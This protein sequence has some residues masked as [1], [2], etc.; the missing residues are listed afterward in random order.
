MSSPK[1]LPRGSAAAE[2]IVRRRMEGTS[3]DEDLCSREPIHIPGSIQPHGALLA[4][5]ADAL[6]IE[7][8]SA[9]AE[10]VL[11]VPVD[12]LLGRPLQDAVPDGFVL[13]LQAEM[14]AGLFSPV[15]PVHMLAPIRGG[16]EAADCWIHARDGLLVVEIERPG[17]PASSQ[18]RPRDLDRVVARLRDSATLDAMA[19]TLVRDLRRLTGFQRVLLYRFDPDWN[20]ET[21]AEDQVD[22][23]PQS[24]LGLRFPASDIPRQAR[25][26]YA[27]NPIRFL[28]ERDYTP[29]PLRSSTERNG[30]VLDLTG[31][32]LRSFS[33]IHLEYQR[34][35]G[36]DGAMS[37]SVLRDGKLWGLVVGHHRRPH[38]VPAEVA[39]AIGLVVTA[40]AMRLDEVEGEAEWS[41]HQRQS[42]TYARLLEQMAASDDLGAA[43]MDGAVTLPELFRAG[44]GALVRGGSMRLSGA[45]PPA[46]FIQGLLDWARAQTTERVFAH[47]SLPHA[48]AEA[49]PHAPSASG[50]LVVFLGPGREDAI[51]WFRS[52][53]TQE[54][55]WAGDPRKPTQGQPATG[56]LPRRSF[57]RWVENRTG[58]AQPWSRWEQETAE[59]LGHAIDEVILRH[60]RKL[61]ELSDKLQR[62]EQLSASQRMVEAS[63]NVALAEKDMLLAQKDVL[64]REVDHRV[65]NS[66]QLISSVM[67]L[68]AMSISDPAL[69]AEFSQASRRVTSVA[70]VHERLY[71]DREIRKVE[72]AAYLR[73]LCADLSHTAGGGAAIE[74]E[75]QPADVGTDQVIHLG[76]MVNEL[77]TNAFKYAAARSSAGRVR[78]T[79]APTPEGGYALDVEDDGPGVPEGFDPRKS[80]GLGMRLVNGFVATMGGRIEVGRSSLGGARFS[81][82]MPPSQRRE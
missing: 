65:K 62:I 73:G 6:R 66:L 75:A 52:E 7:V 14:G 31:A 56:L 69:R 34:A 45:T 9:N 72:F 30:K 36:V 77:V 18:G 39:S 76:L 67:S 22:D 70:Q 48:F 15:V 5:S 58:Y 43:L 27:Q 71:R 12:R 74:V 21:I 35:I 59:V 46:A 25:E 10:E 64:L 17:S 1:D 50:I 8:C 63:L 19:A 60:Q 55:A 2:T 11:G 57:E 23:W 79:F 61:R 16:A 80:R 4:V 81:V 13:L 32:R 49:L 26:L 53:I 44:G 78:V 20:G 47:A 24:F 37:A 40:F 28:P 51:V 33:P 82:H 42:R 3:L 41:E 38:R 68:Q 29:V 54:I